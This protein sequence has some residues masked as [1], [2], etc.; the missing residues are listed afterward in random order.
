MITTI[1]KMLDIVN[2]E[3]GNR[4][5]DFQYR[6]TTADGNGGYYPVSQYESICTNIPQMGSVTEIVAKNTAGDDLSYDVSNFKI[7]YTSGKIMPL[8]TASNISEVVITGT[9]WEMGREFQKTA[10]NSAVD[11]LNTYY[12]ND[13]YIEIEAP[14]GDT[15]DVISEFE[16]DVYPFNMFSSVS[17]VYQHKKDKFSYELE[18]RGN[19]TFIVPRN[20]IPQRRSNT[21][22]MMYGVI[23]YET[24]STQGSAMGVRYP[25]YIRGGIKVP[26]ITTDYDTDKDT[27]FYLDN[28]LW[29]QLKLRIKFYLV[30]RMYYF[31]QVE[32]Q[33]STAYFKKNDMRT[34]MQSMSFEIKNDDFTLKV[35]KEIKVSSAKMFPKFLSSYQPQ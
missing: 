8:F 5:I 17:G 12:A 32:D 15:G 10:W 29:V 31:I 30:E 14:D 18:E 35:P 21:Q 9:R 11:N 25:F 4:E 23:P 24:S 33:S 6:Y 1:E 22:Y 2:D 27:E 20:K 13:S 28:D 7:D 34:I 26:L 16:R 3:L 19:W